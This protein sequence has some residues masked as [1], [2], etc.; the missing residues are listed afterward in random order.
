MIGRTKEPEKAPQP[1][2]A[3][4][5]SIIVQQ[6]TYISGI[7][8]EKVK[9]KTFTEI[10]TKS[11]DAQVRLFPSNDA[12]L[13]TFKSIEEID[14]HFSE[15]PVGLEPPA[16]PATL[17]SKVASSVTPADPKKLLFK[18]FIS[19]YKQCIQLHFIIQSLQPK[20]N[21]NPRDLDHALHTALHNGNRTYQTLPPPPETLSL[22]S[23]WNAQEKYRLG[24]QSY[25]A[26]IETQHNDLSHLIQRKTEEYKKKV[27]ELKAI[28]HKQEQEFK[29]QKAAL[30]AKLEIV[31]EKFK[32]I[33]TAL[34]NLAELK[35]KNA[36]TISLDEFNQQF[37]ADNIAAIKKDFATSKQELQQL[38]KDLNSTRSLML[39]ARREKND[40]VDAL[41]KAIAADKNHFQS[42]FQQISSGVSNKRISL[43][44]QHSSFIQSA[45]SII[46]TLGNVT[47]R[48]TPLFEVTAR[49]N[50]FPKLDNIDACKQLFKLAQHLNES[51][52]KVSAQLQQACSSQAGWLDP[53]EWA[54]WKEIQDQVTTSLA[55]IHS[56]LSIYLKGMSATNLPDLFPNRTNKIYSNLIERKEK[57]TTVMQEVTRRHEQLTGISEQLEALAAKVT[58]HG[59]TLLRALDNAKDSIQLTLDNV[60][61]IDFVRDDII[62]D[63]Q[64]TTINK[65]ITELENPITNLDTTFKQARK[66]VKRKH[67]EKVANERARDNYEIYLGTVA[68]ELRE[69]SRHAAEIGSPPSLVTALE[70]IK[71]E[72]DEAKR[73]FDS[74]KFLDASNKAESAHTKSMRAAKELY[75]RLKNEAETKRIND[76]KKQFEANLNLLRQALVL[77]KSYSNLEEGF[78]AD[79]QQI[80]ERYNEFNS[81][82]P[83]CYVTAAKATT[84]LLEKQARTLQ[85]RAETILKK[86]AEDEEQQRAVEA[87]RAEPTSSAQMTESLPSS[88]AE[89]SVSSHVP[90]ASSTHSQPSTPR[91]ISIDMPIPPDPE[92]K[93]PGFFRRHWKALVIGSAIGLVAAGAFLAISFFTCGIGSAA[94]AGLVGL[95]LAKGGAA[96]IFIGGTLGATGIG[97]FSVTAA[98]AGIFDSCTA[99]RNN[100]KPVQQPPQEMAS[101]ERKRSTTSVALKI[102][103][104]RQDPPASPLPQRRTSSPVVEMR[105]IEQRKYNL[106]NNPTGDRLGTSAAAGVLPPTIKVQ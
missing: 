65:S 45:Q 90:D 57:Y 50:E 83:T 85:A 36:A 46:E 68:G 62:S 31:K 76:G 37:S 73:L 52:I 55:A 4:L 58:S 15:I 88:Y 80:E 35:E 53:K 66:E 32:N 97:S 27:V 18:E 28:F 86:R 51:L 74:Q 94:V 96:A 9:D 8:K 10:V 26:Q 44:G 43:L 23:A 38:Q 6:L 49:I 75:V 42:E 77:L 11:I 64:F 3:E 24:L 59:D 20:N 40:R 5:E 2:L 16:P 100:P 1:E 67:E 61:T 72:L 30:I 78:A 102:L 89:A 34:K 69:Y 54:P 106:G 25:P 39:A 95:G 56:K 47:D 84:E 103:G 93:S 82:T 87:Q 17:L 105:R 21:C 60:L 98:G 91:S 71:L 79:R 70:N 48:N 41:E 101:L 13:K 104:G 12:K 92:K 19:A 99:S 33:S 14:A 29:E 81:H 7:I 63:R 22:V